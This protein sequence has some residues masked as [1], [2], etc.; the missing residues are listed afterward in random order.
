MPN[1]RYK[2]QDVDGK[3]VVGVLA[4]NDEQDLHERLK[5]KNLMLLLVRDGC[6]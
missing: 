2:A 4:A 3:S 1:F 5:Q 6:M